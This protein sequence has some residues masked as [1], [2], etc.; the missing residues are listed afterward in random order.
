MRKS[1]KNRRYVSGF[2]L[3]EVLAALTIG[4]MVLVAVLT[5]YSR[6]ENVAAGITSKL[7]S[8][9]VPF[10]I[11]QRIAEDLDRIVDGDPDT[12]VIVENKIEQGYQGARLTIVRTISDTKGKPQTFEEIIWQTAYDYEGDA[13]GLVLYRSYQGIGLEDKLLDEQRERW[14]K[15]YHFVPIC[16]GVTFFKVLIPKQFSVL[17]KWTGNSLPYGITA[18]VS[19]A[20]PF[21]AL[22][23]T[24]GVADADK[25]SRTIA[26]GRTR[27]IGYTFVRREYDSEAEGEEGEAAGE[28][29][30]DVSEDEGAAG[31]GAEEADKASEEDEENIEGQPDEGRR[32]NRR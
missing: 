1:L 20:E 15:D 22:D 7:D 10:E 31:A 13:N 12:R 28:D 21:E 3:A 4:S 23:G 2:S 32:S 27:R 29:S 26:V 16:D 19:F 25:I 14:E 9:Q 11:L 24:W 8:S 17:D 18:I 6:V 5:I 30:N